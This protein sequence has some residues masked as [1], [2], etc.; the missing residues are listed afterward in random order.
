MTQKYRSFSEDWCAAVAA[1]MND[2]LATSGE[3][4]SGIKFV[5]WESF[6]DAPQGYANVGADAQWWLELSGGTF[7]CGL[8]SR[9]KKRASI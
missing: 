7:T 3:N 8:G 6:T 5:L 2:H 4:V 9:E 1:F